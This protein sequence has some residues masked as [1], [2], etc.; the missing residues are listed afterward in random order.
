MLKNDEAV[1]EYAVVKIRVSKVAGN[2]YFH[3]VRNL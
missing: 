1:E 2:V 3:R